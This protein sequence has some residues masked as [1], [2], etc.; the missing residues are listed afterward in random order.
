V[1]KR[2]NAAKSDVFLAAR[3]L[4]GTMKVSF[5]EGGAMRDAFTNEFE[6]RA[7]LLRK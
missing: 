7:H 1:W 4:T 3:S 2:R 5:H 6:R